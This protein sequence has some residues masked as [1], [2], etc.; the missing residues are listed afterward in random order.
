MNM[1]NQQR[2][3]FVSYNSRDRQ[4]GEWIAW[5]LENAGYSVFIQA[6]DFRPGGNFVLDMHKASQSKRTIAVLSEDYL[7]APFPQSEWAAAFVQDPTGEHGTLLPVRVRECEPTGLLKAI[8]YIDLIGLDEAEAQRRLLQGAKQQRN[9]PDASPLFPSLGQT[10][11]EVE[12]TSAMRNPLLPE[13]P[14]YPQNLPPTTKV[15]KV[16]YAGSSS[17]ADEELRKQ[18]EAQ[19]G[20]LREMGLISEWHSGKLIAGT[21]WAVETRKHWQESQVILLLVSADFISSSYKVAREAVERHN[22]NTAVTIPIILRPVDWDGAVFSKLQ[23]LPDKD[24]HKP[25][26]SW[27]N[28]EEALLNVAQGIRKAI[29]RL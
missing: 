6:W 21:E 13:H 5:Q 12:L 3:F 9:K 29:E 2:D 7:K 20:L 26:T 19:L 11:P 17:P 14:P 22:A 23:V 10:V 16:F 25:I 8:G 4:W 24:N 15:V 1:Q 18:I 27:N 28:R